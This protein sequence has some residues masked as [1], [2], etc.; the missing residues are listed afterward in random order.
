MGVINESGKLVECLS[1]RDLVDI[2]FE[3]EKIWSLYD[4]IK[5]FKEIKANKNPIICVSLEVCAIIS[6]CNY[7]RI[8]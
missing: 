3:P 2:K 1:I 4:D 8:R 5:K 7:C 6:M